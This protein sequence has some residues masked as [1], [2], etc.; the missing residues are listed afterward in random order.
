MITSNLKES[1]KK[2][3]KLIVVA[4]EHDLVLSSS[5]HTSHFPR[6][7]RYL[8]ARWTEPTGGRLSKG[9]GELVADLWQ[10][11]HDSQWD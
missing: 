1:F 6:N 9:R 11:S 8:L 4:K 5:N 7:V 3:K 2:D 10:S